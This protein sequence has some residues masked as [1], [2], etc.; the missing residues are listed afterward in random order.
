MRSL[1]SGVRYIRANLS[2]V[3]P[4]YLL[5]ITPLAA[6]V[7]LAIDAVT[8]HHLAALP[9]ASVALTLATLWR[10]WG[11]AILQQRVQS[12]LYGVSVRSLRSRSLAILIIRLFAVMAMT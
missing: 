7:W 4:L 9:I 12:D 3:I 1:D 10:W 2:T 11:Q 8:A 6:A 5:A